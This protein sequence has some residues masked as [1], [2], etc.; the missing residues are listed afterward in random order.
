M[1]TAL[2][3][4]TAL[5]GDVDGAF[6]IAEGEAH[7]TETVTLTLDEVEYDEASEARR[8][9]L[10]ATHDGLQERL[11]LDVPGQ[12]AWSD[13]LIAVDGEL[14]GEV[15]GTLQVVAPGKPLSVRTGSQVTVGK[16]RVG[17]TSA[18]TTPK[19]ATA[20][21]SVAVGDGA[22]RSYTVALSTGSA[23]VPH[24]GAKVHVLG[25]IGDYVLIQVDR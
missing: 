19:G 2:V 23:R 3:L 25:V 13:L 16:V 9:H 18:T 22:P 12:R 14:R 15:S 6:S 20:T 10:L 24:S 7:T 21:V 1:W 4:C 8:V 5:A 17:I 11:S